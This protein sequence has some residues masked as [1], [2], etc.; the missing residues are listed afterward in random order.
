VEAA[1][2][3]E[4]ARR[5]EEELKRTQI[6]MEEKQKALQE[7][8]TTPQQLHV[9]DH[10]EDDDESHSHS[11]SPVH[12]LVALNIEAELIQQVLVTK[13]LHDFLYC[14]DDSG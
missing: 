11:M 14:F 3:E 12:R 7:A 5:L 9:G 8:L 2:K 6:E 13:Y 1:Q 10:D 4:E